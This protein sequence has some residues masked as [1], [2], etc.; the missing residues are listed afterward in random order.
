MLDMLGSDEARY[1]YFK[2]QADGLASLI[3]DL[4][5]PEAISRAVSQIQSVTSRAYGTL[6]Q[7]QKSLM[8]G[9]FL[10]YINRAEDLALKQLE[11]V[12][13]EQAKENGK[14][15]AEEVGKHVGRIADAVVQKLN[16]AGTDSKRI[17][18]VLESMTRTIQ[19]TGKQIVPQYDEV[20]A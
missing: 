18:E 16:E 11:K 17:A 10:E 6:D 14:V 13:R 8:G 19:Y 7:E 2:S 15:M 4:S 5:D 9:E 12:N 1:G 3:T 20:N